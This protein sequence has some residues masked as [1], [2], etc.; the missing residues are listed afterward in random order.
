MKLP[1]KLAA[2]TL[3][4]TTLFCL[5]A[6]SGSQSTVYQVGICQLTQHAA[7]DDSTQGF[8]DALNDKLPGQVEFDT[9]NASNDLTLCS[10]ILNQF[11]TSEADLILANA[12]PALQTAAA[13]TVEIP[14]L[15]TSVTEYS[16]ALDLDDFDG[17]IGGNISG[18][19]DLAPLDRQAAMLQ[20][21]FPS[22]QTVALLYCSAEAN[23]RYQADT[24]ET[25]LTALGYT[26]E[27][28]PFT[29]SNDLF[30]VVDS[31]AGS[32]DV[33][34]VPTDNTIAAC[35]AIIDNR[36]RPDGIPVMGGDEAIC[37]A[38]GVAALCIDYYDLGYTTGEMAAQIL[39]GEADIAEMPIQYAE[40]TAMY[41]PE[42][43]E[44]LG[45]TP[46]NGYSAVELP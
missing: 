2:L 22:A 9:Q 12:T 32:A 44:A 34:F 11:V 13:A 18:T 5:S 37:A 14:I 20:E 4:V 10:T 16:A 31:A 17:L 40:C 42:T 38:C 28:F 27:H 36:C 19:S 43:C 41:N 25:E 7:L 26:C 24:M 21:W 39:T 29:D 8:I 45:L 1:Y 15:S 3:T 30:A 33:I 35:A 6:C 46:P 23:S